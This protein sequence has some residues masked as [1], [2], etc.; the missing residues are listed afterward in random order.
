MFS[1]RLKPHSINTRRLICVLYRRSG[2]TV[3]NLYEGG[4]G[5]IWLSGVYC[6][7]YEGSIAECR[8]SNWNVHRCDIGQDVSIVCGNS[9]SYR[10]ELACTGYSREKV[11]AEESLLF[12][13]WPLQTLL[14]RVYFYDKTTWK[15]S[16]ESIQCRV[17]QTRRSCLRM[18]SKQCEKLVDQGGQALKTYD[19]PIRSC[20]M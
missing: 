2:L 7:G 6:T 4:S 8:H 20:N 17:F 12:M 14:N 1:D 18:H 5:P 13:D 16:R 19:W 3:R 9:K 11:L 15:R 10:Y